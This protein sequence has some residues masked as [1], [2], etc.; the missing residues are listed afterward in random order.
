MIGSWISSIM[1]KLKRLDERQLAGLEAELKAL[2]DFTQM[3]LTTEGQRTYFRLVRTVARL[4][5]K[6]GKTPREDVK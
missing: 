6:L 1:N 2:E 4:R 5:H 3:Q